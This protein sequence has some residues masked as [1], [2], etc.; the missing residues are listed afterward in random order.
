MRS[1][2]AKRGGAR[3]GGAPWWLQITPLKESDEQK[4][5]LPYLIALRQFENGEA[6]ED[7]IAE[8]A[9]HLKI[10]VY[11]KGCDPEVI[12]AGRRVINK[13]VREWATI[14]GYSE[15]DAETVSRAI[16]EYDRVV[17]FS[18]RGAL[19]YATKK[20]GG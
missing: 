5:C 17:K 9:A 3:S 7:C 13:I 18:G 19:Q 10:A 2:R 4:Y 14:E 16:H 6:D 1:K 15:E 8:L 12:D 11:L 20:V